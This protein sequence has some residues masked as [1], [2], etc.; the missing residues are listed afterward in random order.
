MTEKILF[1][2]DEA[3]VLEGYQR[4]LHRDFSVDTAIGG[5]Q[6][7]AAMEQQTYA[8]VISDMRMPGMN[9]A[10]F[11]TKVRAKSPETVRML[12]TGY[13]DVNAAMDAVNHGNIFRFLTK[14][15]ERDVLSAAVTSGIEQYR[16]VVGERELLEKTL[17]GS[18]TVLADVLSAANPEIFGRSKRVAHFVRHIM[19]QFNLS[20]PWRFEAAATLSQLGCVTLDSEVLEQAYS[21]KKL[22][23][24]DQARF[25][26]HPAA[27]MELLAKIPR[28]ETVAWMIGQQLKT[29]VPTAVPDVS[30]EDAKELAFGARMVKMGVA[31]EELKTKH[32]SEEKAVAHLRGRGAE[33][34][35]EL[36]NALTGLRAAEVTRVL[37]KVPTSSLRPGMVLDQEIR[38]PQGMLIVARGQEVTTTLLMKLENF[39]QAGL[40]AREMMAFVPV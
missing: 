28:L 30:E 34:E 26:G 9:G 19:A 2:D 33:F 7:L 4:T 29:Q 16:L 32:L 22:A 13:T 10:E 38:N 17:M 35:R 20:S 8:V 39:A 23:P 24:N 25:D 3:A 5:T 37:R 18:I 27:A 31:Y 12:L 14:P 1:V 11:L 36:V 40:V 21:G 15:C 6:G